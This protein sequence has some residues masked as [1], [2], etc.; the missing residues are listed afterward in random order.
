MPIAT[1]F[2]QPGTHMKKILV[3]GQYNKDEELM[4]FENE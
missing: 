1:S 3:L 4:A 2:D